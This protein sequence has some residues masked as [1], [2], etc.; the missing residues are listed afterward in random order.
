MIEVVNNKLESEPN[1][2]LSSLLRLDKNVNNVKKKDIKTFVPTFIKQLFHVNNKD[3]LENLAGNLQTLGNDKTF[4][5]F[6]SNIM[7]D[8][9][10]VN[11][12]ENNFEQI[13]KDFK[14]AGKRATRRGQFKEE[15][16]DNNL[17]GRLPFVGEWKNRKKQNFAMLSGELAGGLIAYKIAGM[18]GLGF[19]AGLGPALITAAVILVTIIAIAV[20]VSLMIAL[21]KGIG[22]KMKGKGFYELSSQSRESKENAQIA[23]LN[24][25]YT[26]FLT[27]GANEEKLQELVKASQNPNKSQLKQFKK[28]S[29]GK[30]FNSMVDMKDFLEKNAKKYK[31]TEG[32]VGEG[33]PFQRLKNILEGNNQAPP[34]NNE[35]INV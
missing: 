23:Y 20:L 6:L 35:E 4:Q 13:E 14:D 12:I 24:R 9:F 18:F 11:M 22:D 19:A 27:F 2:G 28:S 8:D 32:L 21:F 15:F 33:T 30:F 17:K 26:A 25:I 31:K 34:Q 3:K 5:T 7:Q 16:W 1:K 10:A 29:Q